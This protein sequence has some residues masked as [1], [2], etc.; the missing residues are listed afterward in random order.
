MYCRA[1]G[2]TVIAGTTDPAATPDSDANA[3]F[4]NVTQIYYHPEFQRNTMANDIAMLRVYPPFNTTGYILYFF[5]TSRLLKHAA[6]LPFINFYMY[7][8]CWSDKT[9]AAAPHQVLAALSEWDSVIYFLLFWEQLLSG[10]VCNL[11]LQFDSLR[12]RYKTGKGFRNKGRRPGQQDGRVGVFRH[13]EHYK[14]HRPPSGPGETYQ[15]QGLWCRLQKWTQFYR[16]A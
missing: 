4:T 12:Q 2:A 3:Q 9:L 13:V 6:D 15:V 5:T 10:V 7:K 14:R 8:K 1:N 16:G 11:C